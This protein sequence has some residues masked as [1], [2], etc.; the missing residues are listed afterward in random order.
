MNL[1]ESI[2]RSLR[3]EVRDKYLKEL[4]HIQALADLVPKLVKESGDWWYKHDDGCYECQYCG[5]LSEEFP[6]EPYTCTNPDC[7]AVQARKL[8]EKP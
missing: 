5:A 4:D 3:G 2:V 8:Q 6:L 7:P 1:R